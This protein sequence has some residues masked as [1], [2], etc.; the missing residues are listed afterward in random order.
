MN[1]F[2]F[3]TAALREGHF[4][5]V[6]ARIASAGCFSLAGLCI[7]IQ[8]HPAGPNGVGARVVQAAV[9]VSALAVGSRWLWWPWPVYRQ[10]VVFAAWLDASVTVLAVTMSDPVAA[11]CVAMFLGLNGVFV[12]FLLGWRMLLAHLAFCCAV[13]AAIVA[14]AALTERGDLATL[15]LLLAPTLTW[16]LVVS[17]CGGMLVE[18]GRRAVRKTAR[19]AHYD[20]LTGLRNRR[21]MYAA[22]NG[23]L[24]RATGPVTVIA[25]VCDIDGFKNLNDTN[26][27]AAGDAALIEIAEQLKSRATGTDITARIGGDELVLVAITPDTASIDT[28]IGELLTRLEPL[29]RVHAV[30]LP[31]TASIGIAAHST[32]DRHFTTDDVLRHADAAMYDSKRSGGATCAVYRDGFTGPTTDAFRRSARPNR[33]SV[34]T[35]GPQGV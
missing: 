30:G 34:N 12:A 26:G 32:A 11:L 14:Y 21:G 27:H 9:V 22:I 24:A 16:V 10:A 4:M 33:P 7:A 2:R 1:N 18:H 20:P 35:P 6:F 23:A 25:A 13:I 29:T 3:A 17:V 8:F 5:R 15:I 31:L 19:S 28:M